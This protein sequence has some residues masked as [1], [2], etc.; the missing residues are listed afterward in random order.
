MIQIF[1]AVIRAVLKNRP[2][3]NA[4]TLQYIQALELVAKKA[5]LLWTVIRGGDT[6][7]IEKATDALHEALA[8]VDFMNE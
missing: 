5:V 7:A 6:K 3:L 8:K 2:D 4:D 1:Y